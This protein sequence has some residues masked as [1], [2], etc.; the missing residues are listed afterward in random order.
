[1]SSIKTIKRRIKSAKNITQITKAMEMV[2]ASKMRRAQEKALASRPYATK[3]DEVLR[4]MAGLIN[5][6]QHQLLK[7]TTSNDVNTIAVLVL[8]SDKGLCGSFN[9]SLFK[10]LEA[11]EKKLSQTH[12]NIAIAFEYITVGKKARDYV[13]KSNRNLHAEFT[14]LPDRPDYEDILPI[15]HILLSSFKTNRFFKAFLLSTNFVSTLSQFPKAVKLLPIDAKELESKNPEPELNLEHQDYVFEPSSRKV[16]D[17]LLPYYFEL[18]VYQKILETQASEHSA[19]MIA[20]RNASDNAKDIVKY[21]GQQYNRQRQSA[22][23]NEIT[24]LVTSRL[25]VN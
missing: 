17:W 2:A 23:T 18:Q 1:M 12:K 13:L 4:R 7:E 11:L 19:R 15:A 10:N 20:M 22:I 5:P 3:L 24:D 8:S 14:N 25:T 9:S 16:L 21:L 6:N